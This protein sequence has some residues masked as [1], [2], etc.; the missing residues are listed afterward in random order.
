VGIKG[1]FMEKTGVNGSSFPEED[2]KK[3]IEV[4][5]PI[6]LDRLFYYNVPKELEKDISPGK[7][8]VVPF[9]SRNV[10]A[11]CTGYSSCEFKELKDVLAC[12]DRKPI[13]SSKDIE[14]YKWA[15][16]YYITPLWVVMKSA[17]PPE[18][19]KDFVEKF[20]ITDKGL[21]A[22]LSSELDHFTISILEFI[23]EKGPVSIFSILKKFPCKEAPLLLRDM[24]KKNWLSRHE[25]HLRKEIKPKEERFVN[26]T[27]KGMAQ[28]SSSDE[29]NLIGRF[30]S[31]R[32]ILYILSDGGQR[33]IKDLRKILPNISKQLRILQKKGLI[34]IHRK[35]VD[36]DPIE[37][38]PIDDYENPILT[39]QQKMAIEEIRIAIHSRKYRAFLLYGV[40]ASGKTEVYIH[41]MK[42]AINQ[43]RKGLL[44]VPEISLTHQ[45]VREFR[46]RFGKCVALIHSRLSPGERFDTW[47]RIKKGEVNIIIGARSALFAPLDPLGVICVDEEHDSSLKQE[48]GFRYNAR[49][50]AM[51]RAKISGAVVILGSATPSLETFH[52]V[53]RKK[54]QLLR[55]TKRIDDQPLPSVEIVDMRKQITPDGKRPILS[56]YLI[57]SI[58][59][60]LERD[61]GTLLF[62][63]RRGF[64]TF[65][66]CPDCGFV[67]TCKNCSV[68]LVHHLDENSIRCHYCDYRIPASP[69]CPSCKE[70]GVR[71]MGIGTESL[72]KELKAIFPDVEIARIDSDTMASKKAQRDL[73]KKWTG[74][75]IDIITG[76]QMIAKGHHV[77]NLT[78]VGVIMAD[79]SLNLPDFRA[80]ERT[81]Q[82]LTQVAGRAGR[83]KKEGR[84]IIQTY[85]PDHYSII[86]AKDQDFLSFFEREYALRKELGYPP[87]WYLVNIRIIGTGEK[88]TCDY[89]L[90]FGD[91]CRDLLEKCGHGASPII[92]LGPSPAPIFKLRGKYRWQM[93]LKSERRQILHQFVRNL[94]QEARKRLRKKGVQ[95]T[96]DVDPI[97][98][99]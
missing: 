44:L 18:I 96:V 53:E 16:N 42:E 99:L 58:R 32:R 60:N 75:K 20:T 26:I 7:R 31:E 38:E 76:T 66:M 25:G 52:N 89:A 86:T 56:K 83:G 19:R 51:V 35:P 2:R 69:L 87:F 85:N 49:D 73:L 3:I 8:V 34:E 98:M 79:I 29:F 48:E 90:S 4:V 92:P 46:A 33:T 55:L 84:V 68:S 36:R 47:E 62:L 27:A 23:R 97:S 82:L 61:E 57:E 74:G 72:E 22:L 5:V 10:E 54:V 50:L 6:P 81:F 1:D 43:G 15:S 45:L 71:E 11:F 40:T 64:A 70:G 9:R 37:N 93:L 77:P 63:N 13:F 28:I 21:N 14:F 80:A 67:F 12:I 95:F 91:L 88:N 41:A 59:E 39:D 30:S 94:I 78:L 24:E 65:L 17:L